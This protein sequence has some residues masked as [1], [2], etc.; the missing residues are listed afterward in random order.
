MEETQ[1]I[2]QH[3]ERI[4]SESVE[5]I[6]S[7]VAYY[8]LLGFKIVLKSVSALIT[9]VVALVIGSLV[10]ILLSFALAYALGD[11]FGSIALGFLTV[12]GIYLFLFMLLLLLKKRLI[13]PL[14]IRSWSKILHN[15]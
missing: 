15:E 13:E 11:V 3:F 2:T 1:D 7:S 6:K 10:L 12:G 8:K 5:Y 9:L 14:I 4:Q